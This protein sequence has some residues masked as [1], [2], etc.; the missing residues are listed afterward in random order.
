[1]PASK[2]TYRSSLGARVDRGE[3]SAA[4]GR[5]RVSINFPAESTPPV[6]DGVMFYHHITAVLLEGW[7]LPAPF[8]SRYIK[9]R[10]I[11]SVGMAN[12]KFRKGKR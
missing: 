9:V 3:F 10:G 8:P 1:M 7:R 6:Q 5:R 2:T 11:R 12:R 4:L